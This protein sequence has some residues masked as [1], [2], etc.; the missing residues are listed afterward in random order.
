MSTHSEL[1]IDPKS[2][3]VSPRLV[4]G[5]KSV[6]GSSGCPGGEFVREGQLGDGNALESGC[7]NESW[8]IEGAACDGGALSDPYGPFAVFFFPCSFVYGSL[9]DA[10]FFCEE[11]ESWVLLA[12]CGCAEEVWSP[13]ASWVF[14]VCPLDHAF[15]VFVASSIDSDESVDDEGPGLELFVPYSLGVDL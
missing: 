12:E 3:R 11:Q 9:D 14:D 2:T 8:S 6:L 1:Q 13:E 10:G 15:D 4:S 7:G 5:E